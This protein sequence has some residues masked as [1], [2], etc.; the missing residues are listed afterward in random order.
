M[1]CNQL[2]AVPTTS[3]EHL[4]ASSPCSV[5][6]LSVA[7]ACRA[8][9]SS[10]PSTPSCTHT[11]P[12]L[13]WSVSASMHRCLCKECTRRCSVPTEPSVRYTMQRTILLPTEPDHTNRMQSNLDPSCEAGVPATYGQACTRDHNGLGRQRHV[14]YHRRLLLCRA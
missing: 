3:S 14:H 10:T 9:T 13:S 8:S 6:A 2:D 7:G 5:P 4:S 11:R 1:R 12:F